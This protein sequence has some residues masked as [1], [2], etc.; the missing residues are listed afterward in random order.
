MDE[1]VRFGKTENCE[2][3]DNPPL[4]PNGDFEIQVLEVYGFSEL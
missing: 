3:F 4:C 2:T 1:N